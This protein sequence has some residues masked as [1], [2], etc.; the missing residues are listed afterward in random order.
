MIYSDIF[1]SKSFL[2]EKVLPFCKVNFEKE[3]ELSTTTTTNIVSS[4]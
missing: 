3:K 4:V 1:G 2:L